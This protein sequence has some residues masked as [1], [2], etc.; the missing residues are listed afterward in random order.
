M[1]NSKKIDYKLEH[2]YP[3]FDRQKFFD[4]LTD[5]KAWTNSELLPDIQIIKPGKDYPLGL[6]AVRLVLSEEMRI[7]EEI[8]GFRSPEYFSY[9]S[10]NGVMPVNDFLGKIF[11]EEKDGGVLIKY[12]GSFKPK[13]T[14]TG[15]SFTEIFKSA[16]KSAFENLGKTYKTYYKI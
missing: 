13:N 9:A 16:Q 6:G 12:E 2:F 11:I 4:L 1:T 7:E 3:D 8:V 5:Y 10:R 15:S 14:D